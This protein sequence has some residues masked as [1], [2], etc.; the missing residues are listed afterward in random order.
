METATPVAYYFHFMWGGDTELEVAWVF[1]RRDWIGIH[2]SYEKT[3][4]LSDDGKRDEKGTVL[5]CV[6]REFGI[7]LGSLFF[8]LHERSFPWHQFRVIDV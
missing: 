8:A 2:Q 6:M 1:S 3:G 7:Q 5:Q 4:V